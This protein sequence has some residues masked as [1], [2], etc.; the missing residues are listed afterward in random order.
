MLCTAFE[1]QDMHRFRIFFETIPFCHFYTNFTC[2]YKIYKFR[3]ISIYCKIFSFIHKILFAPQAQDL[4]EKSAESLLYNFHRENIL[5]KLKIKKLLRKIRSKN[6]TAGG[7]FNSLLF[8][9]SGN[10]F[11]G[12]CRAAENLKTKTVSTNSQIF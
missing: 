5:V 4:F 12:Q 2:Q 8:P 1:E 7:F 9:L 6:L 10:I 11:P 3:T